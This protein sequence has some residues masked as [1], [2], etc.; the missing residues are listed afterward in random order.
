[1]RRSASRDSEQH[2]HVIPGPICLMQS[3]ALPAPACP[4]LQKV[5]DCSDYEW[6]TLKGSQD[7]SLAPRDSS[8]S[9][10]CSSS[11][12]PLRRVFSNIPEDLRAKFLP[13]LSL[14][15]SSLGSY[16]TITYSGELISRKKKE[17]WASSQSSIFRSASLG[18]GQK[19]I[20]KMDKWT[21]RENRG[22]MKKIR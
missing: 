16:S 15:T 22:S 10:T 12:Y 2:N 3:W 17:L 21:L 8:Y 11:R 14:C 20:R 5:T 19:G 6:V 4:P 7:K 13:L 9:F 1:M 18:R